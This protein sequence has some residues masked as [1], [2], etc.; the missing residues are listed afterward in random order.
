VVTIIPVEAQSGFSF[1]CLL[2]PGSCAKSGGTAVA[3]AV[4]AARADQSMPF[5]TEVLGWKQ[6]NT[7]PHSK[8]T[9]AH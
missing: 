4:S 6:L 5:A 7:S 8:I 3:L 2:L 1:D 9:I